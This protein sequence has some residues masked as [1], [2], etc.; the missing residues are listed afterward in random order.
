MLKDQVCML[1]HVVCNVRQE[2]AEL[3]VRQLVFRPGFYLYL[4][5]QHMM[6]H[7]T[8]PHPTPQHMMQPDTRLHVLTVLRYR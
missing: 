8:A 1:L 2:S 6:Q 5:T 7:P 4:T 3:E